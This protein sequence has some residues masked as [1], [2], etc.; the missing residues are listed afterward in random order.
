MDATVQVLVMFY[1]RLGCQILLFG[2]VYIL[3]RIVSLRQWEWQ[4]VQCLDF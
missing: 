4:A 2:Q 3:G 1:E